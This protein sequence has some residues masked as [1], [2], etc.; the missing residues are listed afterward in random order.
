MSAKFSIITINLNNFKGLIR[1]IESIEKQTYKNFELILI[2]GNSKDGSAK[3]IN[4]FPKV[5]T[6]FSAETDSGIS[7]AFNKG[8]N[9][10]SGN[11]YFFLNSGDEFLNE[12]VLNQVNQLWRNNDILFFKV[13]VNKSTTIPSKR[14]GDNEA[15]IIKLVEIPHQ[16]AFI[17][18]TIFKKNIRYNVDYKIR[19]DYEFFSRCQK[20]GYNFK[21]IPDYIVKYEEG[22]KSMNKKNRYL[23]WKEGITVKFIYGLQI[24]FKDILKFLLYF[25][26]LHR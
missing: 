4:L 14:Y 22:G 16:G 6:Y 17:S 25:P 23:F 3:I 5:I 7:E 21:F 19:M 15:K 26:K 2:D 10:A 20:L 13:L 12:N 24:T 1:T 11:V 9:K 8:I 18:S